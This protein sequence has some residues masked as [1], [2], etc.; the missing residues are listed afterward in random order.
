MRSNATDA[1]DVLWEELRG[2]RLE[3]LKFRR[4]VPLGPFIVDFLCLEHRLV[5]EVDGSQH[6]DAR[7]AYDVGRTRWL[8]GEGFTVVRFW[9]DDVLRDIHNVCLHIVR[10]TGVGGPSP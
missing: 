6:G 3:G 4:Q 8:E 10:V 7:L 1:E 2:R 5:I 9:N